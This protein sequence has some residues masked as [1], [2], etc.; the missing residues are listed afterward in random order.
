M[1]SRIAA[2]GL[3]AG[4]ILGV[5]AGAPQAQADHHGVMPDEYVAIHLGETKA[6]VTAAT[7]LTGCRAYATI[8]SAGTHVLVIYRAFGRD[9]W[10]G[11]TYLRGSGVEEKA[12]PSA[13]FVASTVCGGRLV[14]PR[15]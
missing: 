10:V 8:D 7:G 12:T 3:T 13:E 1:R 2:I 9:R 5:C 14:A 15:V 6:D 11:I 4:V